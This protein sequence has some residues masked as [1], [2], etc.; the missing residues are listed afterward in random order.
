ML[1]LIYGE[2]LIGSSIEVGHWHNPL[3]I[4][5]VARKGGRKS[6]TLISN[7]EI[8]S[9]RIEVHTLPGWAVNPTHHSSEHGSRV[10]VLSVLI[11]KQLH[12]CADSEKGQ[13]FVRQVAFPRLYVK[14]NFCATKGNCDA[15]LLVTIRRLQMKK[16]VVSKN[17]GDGKLFYFL[18]SSLTIGL[19]T[20]LI[21]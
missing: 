15:K 4:R 12:G 10:L 18:P 8:Q 2:E 9:L 17:L 5:Q 19:T 7:Y 11:V 14:A 1:F 21:F 16:K 20:L 13:D 3:A 6:Q